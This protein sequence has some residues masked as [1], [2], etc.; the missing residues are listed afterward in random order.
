[1]LGFYGFLLFVRQDAINHLVLLGLLH[2]IFGSMY[3]LTYHVLVFDSTHTKNRANYLGMENAM[4]IIVNVATPLIGGFLV[5][6]NLFGL[7]YETVFA[8]SGLSVLA[9]IIIGYV[10]PPKTYCGH[11]HMRETWNLVRKEKDLLKVFAAQFFSNVGYRGSLD[12]I[13]LF[14]LFD[15][16]QKEFTL[17]GW[18]AVFSAVAVFSSWYIGKHLSPDKYRTAIIYSGILMFASFFALI[19]IPHIVTYITFSI[20]KEVL[21]PFIRIPRQVYGRN[22]IHIL[23]NHNK[24]RIEFFIIREWFGIGFGRMFSYLLLLP[25]ATLDGPNLKIVLIF[26][27]L[28]MVV[29]PYILSRIKTDLKTV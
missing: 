9:A 23:N 2:G 20:V 8:L 4:S 1:M 17:G 26:M 25:I 3:W 11:L 29:A 12:K 21:T 28:S 6:L 27:A 15:V 24:H 5:T 18:L 16:L 13:L 19:G 10:T 7:G 22:L 14:L